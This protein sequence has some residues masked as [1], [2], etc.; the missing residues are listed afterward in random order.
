M[1]QSIDPVVVLL[2]YVMFECDDGYG[3]GNEEK[4]GS[5]FIGCGSLKRLI[6]IHTLSGVSPEKG[7]NKRLTPGNL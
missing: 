5:F 4:N 1:N 7:K 3:K 6:D 2:V